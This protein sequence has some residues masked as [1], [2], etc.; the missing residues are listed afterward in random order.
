M[1]RLV[2]ISDTH[3]HHR[4]IKLPPGD[5][6]VHAGDMTM[7]GSREE[8]E[9]FLKWM[10][11]QPHKHKVL[12]AGNHDWLFV[13]EPEFARE[14]IPAGV[15]YLE[16]SGVTLD[17]VSF[18]GAPWQPWFYDWAFNLPRNGQELHE[19]WAMIPAGVDVLV[20]H[21]PP[22]GSLDVCRAVGTRE[23][24]SVGD[25]A[26]AAALDRVRPR[27]HVF[28]HIHEGYGQ[29]QHGPTVLVNASTCKNTYRPTNPPLVVDL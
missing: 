2:C 3:N 13:H 21:G 26:L 9:T 4:E 23:L 11:A 25:E 12:I 19:K 18:W 27:V 8:T 29:R 17:G 14:I 7:S 5:V 15:H 6:L 24:V 16:D 28:G 1:T 22:H 10:V 20:T